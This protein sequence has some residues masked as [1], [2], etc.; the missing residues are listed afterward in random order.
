MSNEMM[1]L[2][3][4]FVGGLA[5][6]AIIEIVKFVRNYKGKFGIDIIHG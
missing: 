5:S 1:N 3:F 4:G 2:F 6:Y